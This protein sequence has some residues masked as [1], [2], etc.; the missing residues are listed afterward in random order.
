MLHPDAFQAF[1]GA[2]RKN[3]SD[4]GGLLQ[5]MV[6][7]LGY[8]TDDVIKT[9]EL[10]FPFQECTSNH[11]TEIGRYIF[12]LQMIMKEVFNNCFFHYINILKL[13][14]IF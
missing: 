14:S 11:V 4:D 9:T 10:L 5:T 6:Y 1:V 2:A 7:L 8:E 13:M 12:D 3:L